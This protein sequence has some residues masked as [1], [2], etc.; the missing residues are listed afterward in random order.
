MVK[1]LTPFKWNGI[2]YIRY[3]MK[4][5]TPS[6]S[7]YHSLFGYWGIISYVGYSSPWL[8]CK[9]SSKK[10]AMKIADEELIK[11]GYKLIDSEKQL[12]KYRTL[13]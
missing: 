1:I 7:V 13:L 10:E 12:D 11:L 9:L 6:I 4:N 8:P 5:C 2:S 3:E